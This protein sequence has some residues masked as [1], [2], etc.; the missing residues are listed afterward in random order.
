MFKNIVEKIRLVANIE[1]YAGLVL[2]VILGIIYFA[3][4]FFLE[5]II[6]ILV[7]G[8][9]SYVASLLLLRFAM[10]IENTNNLK[11]S[12]TYK[13]LSDEELKNKFLSGELDGN[14]YLKLLE[15]KKNGK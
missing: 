8:F 12:D 2:S 13:G 3:G 5:G 10:I 11:S 6:Y 7:G 4:G 14:T 9:A 15:D 1:F